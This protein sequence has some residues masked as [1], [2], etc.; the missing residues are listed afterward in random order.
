MHPTH[1]RPLGFGEVL[2]GAFQLFRR[3][4]AV[5]A[6]TTLAPAAATAVGT[7][8]MAAAG[9]SGSPLLA[10]LFVPLWL[11]GV[12]ATAMA[13]AALTRQASQGWLGSPVTVADGFRAARRAFWRMLGAGVLCYLAL[14]AAMMVVLVPI[15]IVAALVIPAA[16]GAGAA[17]VMVPVAL[18][19][20]GVA[21]GVGGVLSFVLPAVVVEGKGPTE[22]VG[23]AWALARGAPVRCGAV[24]LVGFVIAYL[25]AVGLMVATGQLTGLFDPAATPPSTA[26]LALQQLT[27]LAA[28]AFATP[29]VVAAI[30]V[31][32]YDR[33]V[34]AEALDVQLAAHGLGGIVPHS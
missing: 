8:G 31:A 15:G 29:F 17:V 21:V 3:H 23:R 33:R 28:G 13:W 6:L 7:L 10:L 25:P 4:F 12:V 1:L 26:L 34:R 2:D 24:V 11:A 19:M 30:V 16:G 18:G 32:Y 27:L 9:S 14:W 22:A 5:F 20:L